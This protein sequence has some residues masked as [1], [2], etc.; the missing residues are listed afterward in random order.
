MK[1]T[2]TIQA[3]SFLANLYQQ[4]LL[5]HLDDKA[6]DC[7]G[8]LVSDEEC[9]DIQNHVDAIMSQA[10]DWGRFDDAYGFCIALINEE[11]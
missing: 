5:F 4:N 1:I 3:Q 9:Q 10:L 11:L 6:C 2:T 7:I 8:H